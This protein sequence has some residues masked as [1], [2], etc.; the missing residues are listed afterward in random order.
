MVIR[1]GSE[2]LAT[3]SALCFLRTL[4]RLLVVDSTSSVPEDVCQYY[5]RVFPISVSLTSFRDPDT[6][7]TIS[8]VFRS[9]LGL[10]RPSNHGPF[11]QGQAQVTRYM[12]EAAQME[13]QQ[14]QCVKVPR[15]ILRSALDFLS[16]NTLPPTSV[17]ADCLSIIAIDLDCDVSDTGFMT[18]DER[19]VHLL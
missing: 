8:G 17:V 1:H 12:A 6:V 2:Q 18:L 19:C 5:N 3:V 11:T 13:Y 4:R 7:P 15:W 16:M 14:T 10:L 9:K